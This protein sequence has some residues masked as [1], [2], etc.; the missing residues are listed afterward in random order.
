MLVLYGGT[1]FIGRHICESAYD[2]NLETT[3]LSQ[4]KCPE[5]FSKYSSGLTHYTIDEPQSEEALKNAKTV[6]YL[7]HQSRPA[8]S[9]KKLATEIEDNVLPLTRTLN[10]LYDINPEC[11]LI[12]LSS[13]G[14]IYGAGHSTPIPATAELKPTTQYG[15]GK[16]LIEDILDYFR[17]TQGAKITTLR[18][19]NPIGRWQVG[20][21]HGFVTA[22]IQSALTQNPIT[23]Y[24]PG[25]NQRDY[26]DVEDF[27]EF[28]LQIASASDMPT[29]TF[30]IGTGIG[31]TEQNVMKTIHTVL[32]KETLFNQVP[33][34]DV[35]LP[36]AVL[37]VA[38]TKRRLSWNPQTPFE[39]SV[40]KI[41]HAIKESL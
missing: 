27:S 26:F 16:L 17:Q 38:D 37:D 39:E 1:G 13:G 21:K 14:Q 9:K 24:G 4:R 6:I 8:T 33:A 40:R 12:Y 20:T 41:A 35:D 25:L 19:S 34:R 22:A 18:L 7:A 30:N 29:G 31:R 5:F 11:H 10:T 3:I 32:G 36:Y 15:L 23:L 28:L 2:A